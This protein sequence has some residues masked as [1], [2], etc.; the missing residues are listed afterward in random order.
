MPLADLLKSSSKGGAFSYLPASNCLAEPLSLSGSTELADYLRLVTEPAGT[1]L[2]AKP[3]MNRGSNTAL[4]SLM[5][6]ADTVP[7]WCGAV[8]GLNGVVPPKVIS[9]PFLPEEGVT[10]TSVAG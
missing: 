4:V 5:F 10:T 9:L 1:C 6:L 3:A 8:S 7:A 2:F